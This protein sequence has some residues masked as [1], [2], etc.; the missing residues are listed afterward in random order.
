MDSS[1]LEWGQFAWEAA[2]DWKSSE[3]GK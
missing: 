2:K 3:D 1:G